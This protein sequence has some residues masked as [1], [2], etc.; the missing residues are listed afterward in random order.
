MRAGT[1]ER[2]LS[3]P[4]VPPAFTTLSPSFSPGRLAQL[5]TSPSPPPGVGARDSLGSSLLPAPGR[6]LGPY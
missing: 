2:G 4:L 5:S 6:I 1:L 3:V